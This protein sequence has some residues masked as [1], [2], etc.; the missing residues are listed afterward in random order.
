MTLLDE[1]RRHAIDA[2]SAG[3]NVALLGGPSMGK[4]YQLNS[5]SGGLVSAGFDVRQ[6]DLES[7]SDGADAVAVAFGL[8][9]DRDCAEMWRRVRKMRRGAAPL[10]LVFDEFDQVRKFA[11]AGAFILNLRDFAANSHTFNARVLIGSRR[12]LS[13][14]EE[15]IAGIST[16]EGVFDSRH[17]PL[18]STADIEPQAANTESASETMRWSGG[19]P[20]LASLHMR[21]RRTGVTGGLNDMEYA[22]EAWAART[23]DYFETIGLLAAVQQFML[24]PVV[25][26]RRLDIARLNA[27]GVVR[28][29]VHSSN[30]SLNEFGPF[31]EEIQRRARSLEAWGSRGALEVEARR[32]AEICLKPFWSDP[33]ERA[34]LFESVL[35]R[36]QADIAKAEGREATLREVVARLPVGGIWVAIDRVWE[37]LRWRL[38]PDD[39][40]YWQVR[41]GDTGGLGVSPGVRLEVDADQCAEFALEVAR[42][43]ASLGSQ[44]PV[45]SAPDSPAVSEGINSLSGVAVG[46]DL[47]V[48]SGLISGGWHRGDGSAS[49]WWRILGGALALI[50]AVAAVWALFL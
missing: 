11:D 1:M 8:P 14:I 36:A 39:R 28:T 15:S 50:S 43:R 22:R 44:R 4:T 31:V 20:G 2:L 12:P 24:G 10:V 6:V 37:R 48:Q 26:V 41:L 23:A 46:R 25:D 3:A 32:L 9:L 33:A 38:T 42:V 18:M 16:L 40:D 47:V 7:C 5:I 29:G 45:E 35:S 13:T 21:N 30:R 27:M 17:L 19:V 34:L 49:K